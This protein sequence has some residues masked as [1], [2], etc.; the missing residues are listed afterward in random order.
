MN[1]DWSV[2]FHQHDRFWLIKNDMEDE[3]TFN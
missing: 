2:N 3:L 1:F